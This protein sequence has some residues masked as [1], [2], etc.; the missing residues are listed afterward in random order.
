MP[1]REE[2]KLVSVLFVDIVGSTARA[3]GAD[4]EDIRDLLRRFHAPV[5]RI[6]DQHGGVIEKFI[7]DAVVAVFGARLAHGDDALRA[8]RCGLRIGEA[9]SELNAQDQA[10]QLAIRGAVATGEAVVELGADAQRGEAIAVGDVMNTAARL[11]A[12][13]PPGGIVVGATTERATR[14]QVRYEPMEPIT[15]KGIPE[16]VAAWL[17]VGLAEAPAREAPLVGRAAEL[18]QLQSAVDGDRATG[19]RLRAVLGPPG[20][21]KSRLAAELSRWIEG[22]GGATYRGRCL[23]YAERR[24]YQA[25]VDQIK[26]LAGIYEA[27][28]PA[29]ARA[30][31]SAAVQR[32]VGERHAEVTR[33]LSLLLALGL[34]EPIKARQPL[35]YAVRLLL[36]GLAAEGPALFVFDDLHWADDSQFE[37]IDYLR[38]HL[39]GGAVLLFLARPE[40]EQVRGGWLDG[41]EVVR[42]EPLADAAAGALAHELLGA[43]ADEE[44][45]ERMLATAGGNPLFLEELTASVG[46]PSAEGER[47]PVPVREAISAHI[48]ALPGDQRDLL[49]DAA[50]IGD[51]FWRGVLAAVRQGEPAGLDAALAALA[52]QG[53]VR[54]AGH[55]RVE[56]DQQFSF[57]HVLVQEV[58]YGTLTRAARRER[59]A[60]VAR[61]VEDRL[62][63]DRRGLA[64][65]LA[66][67]WRAADERAKAVE[68]LVIAAEAAREAWAQDEV[69]AHYDAALELAGDDAVLRNRIRLRRGLALVGLDDFAAGVAALEEVLPELEAHDELE[70]LLACAFCAYWMEDTQ[71]ALSYGERARRLAESVGDPELLAVAALYQGMPHEYTGDLDQLQARYEEARALWVPGTRRAELASLNEYEGD[72]WYWA[73]DYERAERLARSAYEMGGEGH[74]LSAFL[75]GGGW[76]GLSLAGQGR[77]EEA[78]AWL[79]AMFAVAQEVDPRWGASTLN[80]SS[81]P[82]RDMYRLEEA[83][84]RNRRAL[85]L[86]SKRGAWGMPELQGE[87]DLC[88]TDLRLGEVGRVQ[89]DFPRLWDAAVN[90]RAWRPWLGG[91]RLALVRAELARQTE[92]P[93]EL[94][95]WAVETRDRASRSR[96]R[97]YEAS[98]RALLG[99]AL[100]RLG[101][102]A[103]ARE[104]LR[105]AVAIADALGSPTPRWEL[106]LE[107]S[108]V[109]YE[110]GDDAGAEAAQGGAAELMRAY[111]QTLSSDNATFFLAAEPVRSVLRPTAPA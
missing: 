19:V 25:S 18:A 11:Q 54:A 82:L 9:V 96:R 99:V 53:L 58:A 84:E 57:K 104:E 103:D 6:V 43:D 102:P 89:R 37:L 70:A 61:H 67:H 22:Q 105:Q 91:L 88:L 95:R 44:S 13:A 39:T 49:L 101:R 16:P 8:V 41:V 93:E 74:S 42:L 69:V 24:A 81:L 20:M 86:V 33:H 68:Y 34:D 29:V 73:G 109:L 45:V 98:A 32:H 12:A 94:A 35:F 64:A 51:T 65:F 52:G 100:V 107:Q 55:S 36:E 26:Q 40:L 79:E 90:G 48:D 56:D 7:G 78:L 76:R 3:H 108:Q 59:H 21:G 80:Y 17:A 92:D 23:P 83:A 28:E 14:R 106:R 66:H 10:L 4:P 97:K 50:V 87:I 2:R 75:R 60:A 62:G 71:A 38:E 15:A 110:L 30:K 31:L 111:A 46:Q 27:D 85:D 77:S 5:R 72:L 47:L 63:S 1:E